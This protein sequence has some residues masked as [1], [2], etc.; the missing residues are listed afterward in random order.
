VT[1][2][3]LLLAPLAV[4][5]DRP[6]TLASPTVSTWAAIIALAVLSTAA[7]YILYFQI[8]QWAGATNLLLGTFL[9]PVSAIGLFVL[10]LG[11]RLGVVQLTG[12]L[13]IGT[14]LAAIDGRVLRAWRS[15]AATASRPTPPRQSSGFPRLT[16]WAG[17]RS[18][19]KKNIAGGRHGRRAIAGPAA[20]S[21]QLSGAL[22]HR[23]AVPG[24]SGPGALARRL[25]LRRLRS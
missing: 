23:R 14:G 24:V 11:E 3:T 9:I 19:R 20:G 15:R 17:R 12:T 18:E 10:F 2:S 22:R 21:A 7:A 13:L 8:L 6:W 1:A 5:F 25:S 16:R 4:V